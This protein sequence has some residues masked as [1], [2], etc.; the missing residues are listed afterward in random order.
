MIRP[1]VTTPHPILTSAAQ[2]VSLFDHQLKLTVDDMAETMR[3]APGVG[4]AAPQIGVDRR[5]VVIEYNQPNAEPKLGPKIP[6]TIFI[7]PRVSHYSQATDILNEGCLSIPG[8]E[9]PI[10]RSKKIKLTAQSVD[11]RPIKV[12]TTGYLAR[13]IQHEVDHLNGVLITE[14]VKK[15]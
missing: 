2:P 15:V 6:L 3:H 5:I 1:I 11:G 12:Q 7:N 13:I 10:K 4:L 14:R 9:L 8:V